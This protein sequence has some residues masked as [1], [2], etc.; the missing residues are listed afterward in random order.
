EI[1]LRL[2]LGATRADVI[3][4]LVT[5]SVLLAALGAVAAVAIAYGLHSALVLM[6]AAADPSFAMPFVVDTTIGGFV[7]L[8]TLVTALLVGALPAWQTSKLTPGIVLRTEPRSAIGYVGHVRSGRLL[9]SAQLALSLPLLVGAGLLVRT[10]DNLQHMDLGF[11]SE[12]MVLLRLD[13]RTTG[14]DVTRRA[15]VGRDVVEALQR[16][17][18]VEAVT[19]SG[20]GLF[21]GGNSYDALEVEGFHPKTDRDRGAWVDIVGPGYFSTL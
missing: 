8:V 19:Y 11:S 14:D 17:P 16:T 3:R 7:V 18:G 13:L 9:V 5:E 10:V 12:R 20:L 6:L 1:A 2:S 4:Q 21:Q 15:R